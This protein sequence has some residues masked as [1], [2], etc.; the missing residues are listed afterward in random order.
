VVRFASVVFDCDSTLAAIEGIDQLAAGHRNEVAA[1]TDAAMRGEVPLE[2]VYGRRLELIRPDRAAIERLAALYLDALVPDARG[3]VAA[4]QAAGVSVYIVSGGLVPPV[5]AVARALGVPRENVAAVGIRFGDDGEY[6]G[7][8]AESPL[9]R[10]DGKRSVIAAWVPPVPRP[11][12][13]VGDGATDL[14]ARPAVDAFAAYAG[15]VARDAVLAEADVVLIH[16][17]LAPVA[18]LALDES[19]APMYDDLLARG[20]ALLRSTGR[21]LA[22]E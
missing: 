10:Q 18:A 14:A 20:R 8:E 11:S 3:T 22:R 15:V 5:A 17:S 16:P 2:A 13:L 19:P 21:T 1:L 6:A 12:L 9:A 4:L 7:F